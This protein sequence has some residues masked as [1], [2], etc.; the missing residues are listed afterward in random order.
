MT[1][2]WKLNIYDQM[3]VLYFVK[4]GSRRCPVRVFY[5]A[6]GIVLKS[7]VICKLVWQSNICRK[8]YVQKVA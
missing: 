5:D 8:V 1:S 3:T 6:I 7:W 2:K 4:A